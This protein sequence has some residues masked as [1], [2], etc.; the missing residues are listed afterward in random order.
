MTPPASR[1]R[2]NSSGLGWLAA[3]LALFVLKPLRSRYIAAA[4]GTAPRLTTRL[5][6]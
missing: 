6:D 3:F 4:T 2:V 1:A 5:A